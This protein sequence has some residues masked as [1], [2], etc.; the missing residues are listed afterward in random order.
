MRIIARATWVLV[1]G[2]VGAGS[3]AAQPATP[4]LER[5]L[6]TIGLGAQELAAA[7][8]GNAVVRRLPTTNDR[9]VAVFGLIGVRAP[10]DTVTA[11]AVDV[12]RLLVA[13]GGRFQVF[14]SRPTSSDVRG[15]AFDSSEYRDLRDC[16]PGDC[17][18]KMPASGM[19]EFVEGIDWSS[20]EAK[21]QADQK[22]RVA[23]LGL[24]TD[25]LARGN[26]AMLVYDDVR[27]VRSS[28]VFGELVGQAV[29]LQEHAPELAAYLVT[30]PAGRPPRAR[31]VLYW[32]EDRVPRL[33]PMF[34]LNHAVVY[35]P[36]A[37]SPSEVIVA[38][39][40]IYANHYFEGA[41]E[42]LAVVDGG[43]SPDVGAYVVIVRRFRFDN[44]PGGLQ[45]IRGMVRSRLV[46]ATRS[47]LERHWAA[48]ARSEA[49]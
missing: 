35:V 30:Y 2:T 19:R 36:S 46:E 34:T 26:E 25:Y 14:G 27:G 15:A 7:A 24:A 43:E 31:D 49:R 37:P 12:Q 18:F 21:T 9:D 45:N 20:A 28:D 1:S 44:L 29:E 40:Q 17:D 10:R 48:V 3:A 8:R 13:R 41:L 47:D 4:A 39:K 33:R 23:L 38:R 42:L 22:F 5:Y 32:S 16:R 11:R 6:Q